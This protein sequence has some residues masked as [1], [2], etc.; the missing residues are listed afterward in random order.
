MKNLK[1]LQQKSFAEQEAKLRGAY[2]RKTRME[3]A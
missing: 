1:S 3:T 2:E